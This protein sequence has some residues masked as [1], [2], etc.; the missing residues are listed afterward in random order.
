M[1]GKLTKNK[2]GFTII[3][4]SLSITFI[5]ILSLLVVVM[6]MNAVSS[7]HRGI[8]LNQLNTVGMDIVDDMR[9]T[10]QG[11][12]AQS[13]VKMCGEF[14]GDSE[15][16]ADTQK[17]CENDKGLTLV[18]A[19]RTGQ[20]KVGSQVLE[21]VPLFGTFC[22]GLYSYIWNSGYFFSD[23]DYHVTDINKA[24]LKYKLVGDDAV[25]YANDFRLLKVKDDKR[26]VCRAAQSTETNGKYLKSA[27]TNSGL[28]SEFDISANGIEEEPVDVLEGSNNLAFYDLTSVLP[29]ESDNSSNMFYSV[30]FILGTIQGGINVMTS[31]N[32]CATPEGQHSDV[33][34]FDY[35]AINKFNFAAQATGED[36]R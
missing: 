12:T 17:D 11:S 26:L 35:C 19:E 7:Y 10:V 30:S 28:L 20:V 3:E 16:G 31:G 13:V 1:Q 21:N 23:S 18:T 27:N 33:E 5:S 2:H 4:L 24:S 34:N 14:Y 6:I 8:T 29:A 32:Y 36:R 15:T 9:S 25:L 22:T